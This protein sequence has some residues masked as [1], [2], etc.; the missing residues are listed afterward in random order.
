MVGRHRVV[1][2]IITQ[3]AASGTEYL[4][5]V[6]GANIEDLFDAAFLAGDITAILAKHEF[7]AATMADGYSRAVAQVGVVA[8]TSGGGSLNLVAGLGESLA[9]RVPVLAL[10]GQPPTTMDGRGSFQDTSG[11]S[12]SLDALALFS[13]VSVYCRRVT[14]PEDIVP[15][16]AE[17][18]TAART[19]GPAVLLLPKDV[20]QGLIDMVNPVTAEPDSMLSDPVVVADVLR[21][22]LGPVTIIA[23][24]QVARDDARRELEELRAVLRAWVATVPDAKDVSGSPGLGQSSWLGVTGVMGHPRV[25]DAVSRSAVC[26]LVGTRLSVTARAGLDAALAGVQTVSLGSATPYVP[27]A[28]VNSTNLRASLAALTR[29]LTGPG[30]AHGLRVLD[31]LPYTELQPPVYDG[32][33]IRYRDAVSLLDDVLPDG[34]D[35]V[36]DAGN[37]GASAV[38]GLPVRRAGRFVVALGMGGMGYSFGAA[39]GMC[40]ARAKTAGPQYR[41][42]VVAG[43]GSFFMHGMELHTAVQ[44]RLPIT[45]VLFNNNAHAM[46]V[47]REQLFYGDRYSYNRFTPAR[48]GA[49]L[50]AMFPG[51]HATDV[52]ELPQL[53]GALSDALGRH[54]PSVV[55]IECSADEIPTFAP[56]LESVQIAQKT[57][58]ESS[59]HVA[60]RA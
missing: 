24:E 56:F 12:G 36:V 32:P 60:A 10:V 47:T 58:K 49:G 34:A 9:S 26:L 45:F 31:P 7:S 33:G 54:G 19:G 40:F 8:A 22:A 27:C 21:R 20:Q 37:T 55:S 35:V 38:H 50:A 43:D 15:A 13:A 39:I 51:L 46:C 16:L 44:Y 29:S 17:A 57:Q 1:D 3:L 48:L 14:R 5:G 25:V 4:F 23:G 2:H 41:T 6:D 11:C 53:A 52:S 42:V 59:E 30:R 28:H 18:L